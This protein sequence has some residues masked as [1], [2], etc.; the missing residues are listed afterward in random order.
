M[1]TLTR[2]V[3]LIVS[4]NSDGGVAGSYKRALTSRGVRVVPFDLE[5]HKRAILPVAKITQ[6]LGQHVDLP[7]INT[8]ANRALVIAAMDLRPALVLV[9]T[10]ESVRPATLVQLRVSLPG[11]KIVNVF[12]D[13]LF[14]MRD[15]V[16]ACLPHY[17]LFAFHARGGVSILKERGCPGAFYLPLAADPDTHK[18]V[19]PT[20]AERRTFGCDLV[21]VGQ[22]RAEHAELF[23]ALEG[24]D[25]RIWGPEYWKRAENPWVRSRYQG[26][27]LNNP[28]DYVIANRAAKI[29]LSPI[30]PFDLP[31][32]NMRSF[33]LPVCKT[34]SLVT[35]TEGIRDIFVEGESVA[36]FDGPQ[37]LVEKVRYYLPRPE[38]RARIAEAAFKRVL[39]GKHTYADRAATV[40]RE[41]GLESW[42]G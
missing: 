24:M 14:N 39:D 28:R 36:C 26:R 2:S 31:D 19:E 10:N 20:E 7:V 25:L 23:A 30:D 8:R 38:E 4:G 6:R 1:N 22:Y 9:L 41:V 16:V 18:P 42:L 15:S 21:F 27:P 37:E 34:F 35:R 12:T 5:R 13:M 3:L 32:H 29:A 11:V 17:D 33:E 40:L